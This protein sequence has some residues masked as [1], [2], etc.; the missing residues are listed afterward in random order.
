[1]TAWFRA[2][3]SR[4]NTVHIAGCHRGRIPPWDLVR[5]WSDHAVLD[6]LANIPWLRICRMCAKRLNL[7][8]EHPALQAAERRRPRRGRRS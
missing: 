7:P 2:I 5:G 1:M 4:T 6:H 8:D 3:D